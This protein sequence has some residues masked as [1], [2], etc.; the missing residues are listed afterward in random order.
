MFRSCFVDGGSDTLISMNSARQRTLAE[1][2]AEQIRGLIV[3]GDL[4][5]GEALSETA[6]A[7]A[8]GVSKTPI[9]EALLRL[10]AE[11]LVDVRPQRGTF[12]FRMSVAEVE[13]L[14]EFRDVLETAALRIG[15]RKDAAALGRMLKEIASDMTA[16]LAAD[17]VAR[18]VE[19]DDRFH[20]CI[21]AHCGNHHL[22]RSY[23][24]V[25]LR[26][27]ALRYRLTREPKLNARS[28]KQHRMIA[29]MVERGLCA[30]AEQS[31]KKHI[32]QTL[33]DY[34]STQGTSLRR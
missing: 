28:L 30:E 8:L 14:S 22:A 21:V 27:Q 18:Y 11:G 2:A 33:L 23:I 10:K 7:T 20:D 25:A 13:T 1:Q 9:R 12:V 17:D 5:L 34:T 31:L 32:A 15:M 24:P 16:A 3:R 29:R 19:L 26:M 6:L 4:Q